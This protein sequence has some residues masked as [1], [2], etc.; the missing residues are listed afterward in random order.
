M[1]TP[2][3]SDARAAFQQR[4]FQGPYKQSKP[5]SEFPPMAETRV[6]MAPYRRLNNQ[7]DRMRCGKRRHH[8][9]QRF[10]LPHWQHEAKQ[11]QQMVD[12]VE[13]VLETEPYKSRR[14]LQPAGSRSIHPG[15]PANS[16][17]LR[18]P[19]STKPKRGEDPCRER[20]Q[21][22]PNGKAGLLR[23]D[24]VGQQHIGEQLIPHH[25]RLGRQRRAKRVRQGLLEA[26]ERTVGRKRKRH[27]R[28]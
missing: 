13:D 3:S 24:R 19:R 21:A 10:Q 8:Q 17:A 25:C 12:T 20:A 4:C 1:K 11:E 9:H 2:I 6:P 16:K 7:R 14:R 28:H 26:R 18:L 27:G 23:L 15:S 5:R 22:R